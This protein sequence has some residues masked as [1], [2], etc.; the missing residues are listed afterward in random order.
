MRCLEA[1]E[2]VL[3]ALPSKGIW[4]TSKIWGC[5]AVSA[6]WNLPRSY[7]KCEQE[8]VIVFPSSISMFIKSMLQDPPQE[9]AVGL[10]FQVRVGSLAALRMFRVGQNIYIYTV[11]I[12]FFWQEN[13]QIYGHIRC[14]YTDLANPTY[15]TMMSVCCDQ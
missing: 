10:D 11:Y 8:C 3:K 14:I 7:C 15:V 9:T 1:S 4:E 12:R 13:H 2:R 5:P 6:V